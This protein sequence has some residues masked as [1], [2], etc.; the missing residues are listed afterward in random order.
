MP[1]N[2]VPLRQRP[3]ACERALGLMQEAQAILDGLAEREEIEPGSPPDE[4]RWY[5]H[6][7]IGMLSPVTPDEEEVS[8]G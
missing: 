5:L 2:V 7:A 3:A 8:N 6:D 1:D 4:T